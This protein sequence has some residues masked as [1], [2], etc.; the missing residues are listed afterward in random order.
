MRA[1]VNADSSQP[2]RLAHLRQNRHLL[3]ILQRVEVHGE[4][5]ERAHR[6]NH[7]L[8]LELELDHL[9]LGHLLRLQVGARDGGGVDILGELTAH[10]EPTALPE[11][12]VL[13]LIFPPS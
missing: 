9:L 12:T 11:R 2:V 5:A 3:F 7:L 6:A 8:V 10:L 4:R 13:I 1:A